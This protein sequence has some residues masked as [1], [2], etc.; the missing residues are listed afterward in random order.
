MTAVCCGNHREHI[1][2]VCMCAKPDSSVSTVTDYGLEAPELNRCG[3]EI[4]RPTTPALGPTQPPVQWVSG[5]SW[6]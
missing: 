6:G 3:D 4:F 1:N 5:L 2:I